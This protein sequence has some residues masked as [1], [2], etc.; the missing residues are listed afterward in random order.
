MHLITKVDWLWRLCPG[1]CLYE[2]KVVADR[3]A[4]DKVAYLTDTG[5]QRYSAIAIFAIAKAN[6][7]CPVVTK[8]WQSVKPM[9]AGCM[10]LWVLYWPR[11]DEK[12]W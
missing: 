7:P 10:T 6:L 12:V 8:R 11:R 2:S 5:W 1:H 3:Q 9:H 4:L